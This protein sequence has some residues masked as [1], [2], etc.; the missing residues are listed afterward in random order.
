MQLGDAVARKAYV[1]T[2]DVKSAFLQSEIDK[3]IYLKPF[4]GI[5]L[6]AGLQLNDVLLKLRKSMY[7]LKQAPK[8]W[9]DDLRKQLVEDLHCRQSQAD[10]CLYIYDS[11]VGYMT[12]ST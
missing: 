2:L 4:Q 8:L 10:P 3:E 9:G 6:P 7:G 12:I 11:E 1:A 5:R